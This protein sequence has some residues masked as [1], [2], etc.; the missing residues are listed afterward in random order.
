V[1]DRE[2]RRRADVLLVPQMDNSCMLVARAGTSAPPE[3]REVGAQTPKGLRV[4]RTK[5]QRL[6]PFIVPLFTEVRA[7]GILRSL[8][9]GCCIVSPWATATRVARSSWAGKTDHNLWD[10][11]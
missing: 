7:S 4:G 5:A 11:G 6:W 2:V 8:Y 10:L 3:S 1:E 9:A